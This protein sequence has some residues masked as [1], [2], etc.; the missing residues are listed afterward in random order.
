[1]GYI[2]KLSLNIASKLGS[3]LDKNQDEIEILNYGLFFLIHTT[4]AIIMTIIVGI[5][6]NILPE[7]II[8][9]IVAALLK[10]YSGGVHSST[11]N[12][13]IA[14]GL[15]LS[16]IISFLGRSIAIN[17]NALN[18]FILEIVILS[19]SF[20]IIYKKCPVGSKNK[21][22]KKEATRRKLRIKALKLITLYFIIIIGLYI[23]YVIKNIYFIKLML[24]SITMGITL[25]VLAM[26]KLGDSLINLL[27]KVFDYIKFN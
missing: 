8:V 1:M 14:S 15:I 20:Y 4:I 21:P 22:L 18:L 7:I 13:C 12:R 11:P 16:L 10:R 17:F 3:R 27:E 19:T 2:E 5:I 26:T 24:A 9:S 23:F 6:F 25:Q